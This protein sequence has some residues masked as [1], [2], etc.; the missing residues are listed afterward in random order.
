MYTTIE[1]DIENGVIHTSEMSTLPAH[2]HVLITLLPHALPQRKPNWEKIAPQLG[3]LTL[4]EDTVSWQ[5]SIRQE[6]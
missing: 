5:R 1:A 2:A 4:R 3:K 6:W